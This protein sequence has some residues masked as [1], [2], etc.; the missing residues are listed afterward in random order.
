MSSV[1]LLNSAHLKFAHIST[2]ICCYH[3]HIFNTTVISLISF[4]RHMQF[5]NID[6]VCVFSCFYAS[7]TQI[8]C[9]YTFFTLNK[10]ANK[11]P[12]CSL[13]CIYNRCSLLFNFFLNNF[14]SVL[15]SLMLGIYNAIILIF[16]C[17]EFCNFVYFFVLEIA[18]RLLHVAY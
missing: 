18:Q 5:T 4:I 8:Y 17:L 1:N 14:F 3:L 9:S 13:R 11:F 2:A 7:L 6:I 12:L 15:G 16:M 10:F